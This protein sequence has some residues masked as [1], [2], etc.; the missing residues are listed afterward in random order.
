[1]AL[2]LLATPLGVAAS[3]PP[4]ARPSKKPTQSGHARPR[5]ATLAQYDAWQRK[6]AKRWNI[7]WRLAAAIRIKESFNDPY[8]VS[9]TGAVG[10]MQ[11][12]PAGKQFF[13]TRN[14]RNF[15]RARRHA[16]RRYRG[17]SSR[18]WGLSYQQDLLQLVKR[19][20]LEELEQRDRR[21]DPRWN[22]QRGT[23]HLA[24]DL[25]RFKKRYPRA[26][27]DALRRMTVAAYYAG[28]GRVRYRH[29]RPLW[30]SYVQG[31]VEDLM[32]VYAR[33]LAGLPGR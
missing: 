30:P 32:Q 31:Y 28:P 14:Y 13:S 8:Y 19:S 6:A 24:R 33:I 7:D 26:S 16:S 11:L 10:L 15:L 1:M 23:A 4:T 20:S 27:A 9:T 17:R 22:I 12:M 3:P 2:G 25:R 29:G 5:A 18:Q 21:F